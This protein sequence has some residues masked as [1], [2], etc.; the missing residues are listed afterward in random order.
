MRRRPSSKRLS[1][2]AFTIAGNAVEVERKA[3]GIGCNLQFAEKGLA[4]FLAQFRQFLL[5][6]AETN[7]KV[8]HQNPTL[9]SFGER[10][11]RVL[12]S[13]EGRLSD[14]KGRRVCGECSGEDPGAIAVAED[15][16]PQGMRPTREAF[17]ARG[18][19][20]E[21]GC[22]RCRVFAHGDGHRPEDVPFGLDVPVQR[23][24]LNSLAMFFSAHTPESLVVRYAQRLQNEPSGRWALDMVFLKLA[25]PRRVSTPLLILGAQR[26]RSVTRQEVH[27]TARAYRSG[28]AATQTGGLPFIVFQCPRFDVRGRGRTPQGRSTRAPPVGWSRHADSRSRIGI[29]S[30]S[31]CGARSG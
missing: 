27:A 16:S 19:L 14:M 20:I 1:V 2:S 28:V 17:S 6:D 22:Q 12:P 9:G 25:K 24:G 26:D 11:A 23:G 30:H 15:A 3:R 13:L 31:R 29:R 4:V 8:A 10:E 7:D 5:F 18:A 21:S